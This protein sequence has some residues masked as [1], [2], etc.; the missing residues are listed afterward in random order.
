MPSP[1]LKTDARYTYE[2]YLTWTN[3]ARWEIIEGV[4]YGMSPAP[5]TAHQ[6]ISGALFSMIYNHVEDKG[7]EVFAAPFDVR[8]GTPD[9]SDKNWKTVVQPDISVI[10][11][12]KKVDDRGCRGTPD[13]IIEIIS[14]STASRDHIQKRR[15]YEKHGVKEYW[16]VDPTYRLVHIYRIG[17]DGGY[18]LFQVCSE[19][20][21]IDVNVLPDFSVDLSQVFPRQ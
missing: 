10:C 4:A 11:D 8:L 3:E 5:T 16:L 15:L 1:S 14:P 21:V 6:R 19:E 17:K 18:S 20:E 7:C 12:E 13:W 9:I 2:D